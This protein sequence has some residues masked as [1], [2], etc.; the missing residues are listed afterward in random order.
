MQPTPPWALKPSAEAS[1]PELDKVLAAGHALLGHSL[2][3]AGGI[4]H[5]N[6][7]LE[8]IGQSTHRLGHHV[9]HR[10]RRDVVD[11]DRQLGRLG[12]GGEVQIE[13]AL[14]R[15]VIIRRH[16]QHG[17]GAGLL[18]M[19]GKAHRFIGV[20]GAC[21]GDNRH[22]ALRRLDAGLHNP[23]MLVMRQGRRFPVVPTGTRPFVP[24]WICQS[25]NA[26]KAFSSNAP[27]FSK[28]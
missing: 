9:D 1:S 7:V 3:L 18:G 13:P 11:D 5:T 4:L 23:M 17:V 2:D 21:A 12:D 27:P 15:L 28:A 19:L 25:T 22:P 8:I 10:T 16:H 20:V 6:D 14:R 26:R 24:S